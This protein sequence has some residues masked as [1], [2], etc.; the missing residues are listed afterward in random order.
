MRAANVTERVRHPRRSRRRRPAESAL[1]GGPALSVSAR[2]LRVI[3]ARRAAASAGDKTVAWKP[4]KQA[5]LRVDDQPVKNWN[6]YRKVRKATR[7]CSQMGDRYLLI[8]VHERKIFELAPAKVEHKGA[9]LLLGS[10]RPPR[11]TARHLRA[12]SSR[13]WICLSH[14]RPARSRKS[15][16]RPAA[17]AP[18]ESALPVVFRRSDCGS[19]LRASCHSEVTIGASAPDLLAVTRN[20]SCALVAPL[21]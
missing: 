8:Q 9:E 19:G 15:R 11:R 18:A 12:G 3:V 17:S 1:R 20:P 21:P 7:C 16:R 2:A 10:G 6:V 4:V 14:R 5:L 13:R